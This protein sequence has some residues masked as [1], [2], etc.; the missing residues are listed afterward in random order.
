MMCDMC[1]LEWNLAEG[2][3]RWC[4]PDGKGRSEPAEVN[5]KDTVGGVQVGCFPDLYAAFSGNPPDQ[6]ITLLQLADK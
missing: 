5:T 4:G 6:V 2:E 3:P 1:A